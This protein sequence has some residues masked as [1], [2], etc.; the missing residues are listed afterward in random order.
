MH[1]TDYRNSITGHKAAVWPLELKE[2][3][4]FYLRFHSD[5][6]CQM[7]LLFFDQR[8]TW[9]GDGPNWH[10][11]REMRKGA[12]IFVKCYISDCYQHIFLSKVIMFAISEKVVHISHYFFEEAG[13]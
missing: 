2:N 4:E 1:F 5:L 6:I 13:K 10:V 3:Q 11:Q 7:Y 8:G 12:I 9:D